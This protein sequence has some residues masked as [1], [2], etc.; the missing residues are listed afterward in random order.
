MKP[1]PACLSIC[2]DS[3]VEIQALECQAYFEPADPG[4]CDLPWIYDLIPNP[5]PRSTCIPPRSKFAGYALITRA[6][7]VERHVRQRADCTTSVTGTVLQ[8]LTPNPSVHPARSCPD[9]GGAEW[10]STNQ[11]VRSI[12]FVACP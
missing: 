5:D 3:V 6:E 7:L 11:V 9:P 12:R 10:T 8:R 4:G 2:I 1:Y